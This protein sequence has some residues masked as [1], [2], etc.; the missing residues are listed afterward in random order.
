MALDPYAVLGVS[1]KATHKEIHDA[2]R[3]K[4]RE[5]HPDANPGIGPEAFQ[6]LSIAYSSIL[7]KEEDIEKYEH[8]E[9]AEG[10]R[11]KCVKD[12]WSDHEWLARIQIPNFPTKG[13]EYT[14]YEARPFF[15]DNDPGALY[16]NDHFAAKKE[17]PETW[18]VWIKEIPGVPWGAWGFVPKDAI[19]W[20]AGDL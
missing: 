16:S 13:H 20:T 8:G 5:C 11:V 10:L 14:V 3:K 15:R 4:A 7:F 1:R 19:A 9:I 2:Y 17:W 6:I 12:E 18:V